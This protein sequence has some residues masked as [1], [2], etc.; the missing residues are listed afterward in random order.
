MSCTD[1]RKTEPA[2]GRGRCVGRSLL[3]ALAAVAS[4]GA[5]SA[6]F[7]HGGHPPAPDLADH[8]VWHV[9]MAAGPV[10]AIAAVL[11]WSRVRQRR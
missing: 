3:A 2:V 8:V 5:S 9:L 7:A 10:A 4:L 1:L 11:L 6:A